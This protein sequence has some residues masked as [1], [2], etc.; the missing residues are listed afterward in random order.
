MLYSVL[1][2]RKGI[3]VLSQ[4]DSIARNKD[5]ALLQTAKKEGDLNVL[6]ADGEEGFWDMVEKS[7]CSSSYFQLHCI[8]RPGGP[9][10]HQS[11][12]SWGS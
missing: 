1:S 8:M 3:F 11:W 4:D 2:F 7:S 6:D 10:D 12:G 5:G 9:T